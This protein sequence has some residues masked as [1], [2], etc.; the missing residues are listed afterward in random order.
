MS[1]QHDAITSFDG[2]YS[3]LSNFYP[4][5]KPISVSFK[6]G[7][8]L[9]FH[10]VEAAYQAGKCADIHE[11]ELFTRMDAKEA[12]RYSHKIKY[13]RDDFTRYNVMYMEMLLKKKFSDKDLAK[14][15][16]DTA[17]MKLIEG[18]YWNDTFWGVCNGEGKNYLGGLLME[19]RNGLK[20]TA[21][22]WIEIPVNNIL[23]SLIPK[24]PVDN[25][26]KLVMS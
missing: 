15:L 23:G 17:P 18:N 26:Q 21:D 3:F 16:L 20:E 10:S 8:S 11:C 5:K 4:L 6:E 7:V 22:D 19:I 24:E 13:L 14:R 2:K 1:T 12:K 9:S 25:Q